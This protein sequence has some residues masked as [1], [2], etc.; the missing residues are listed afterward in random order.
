VACNRKYRISTYDDSYEE[1]IDKDKV[2]DTGKITIP[3]NN[4]NSSMNLNKNQSNIN[5]I[6]AD[7]SNITPI[8]VESQDPGFEFLSPMFDLND[9]PILDFSSSF[10]S[11]SSSDPSSLISKVREKS[12]LDSSLFVYHRILLIFCY[13]S[14]AV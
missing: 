11:N 8:I 10:S 5:P 9:A 4:P 2:K 1:I 14:I 12:I 6:T 3:E 13:F 7:L